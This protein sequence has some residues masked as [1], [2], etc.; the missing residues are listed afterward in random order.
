MWQIGEL[1][2]VHSKI[3]CNYKKNLKMDHFIYRLIKGTGNS[4]HET[5]VNVKL[6]NHENGS[7]AHVAFSVNDYG[8]IFL[9][10][11]LAQFHF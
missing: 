9:A 7:I 11:F 8:F 4:K 3:H 5:V 1:V 10:Q 2:N 6:L